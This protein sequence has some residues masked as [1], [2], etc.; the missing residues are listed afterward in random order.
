M[1]TQTTIQIK[2]KAPVLLQEIKKAKSVLLHCHPNPDPDSVGSALAMKFVLEQLGIK[3]TVIKGDSDIPE[4]FEHF[5]GCKEI[6]KKDYFEID[7]SQYDLFIIVDSASKNMIS[8]KKQVEFPQ[9][10]KTIVIDHHKSNE[11]YGSINLVEYT[12]PATAQ[13]LADLFLEWEIKLDQNISSNLFL[14]IY[15]DS[16]FKY[17]GVSTHTF[18]IATKLS[19]NI[20]SIWDLIE[21]METSFSPHEITFKKIALN[22]ISTSLNN[23][24]VISTV[25]LEEI[26]KE[27]IDTEEI[28][29]SFISTEL[30]SVKGWFIS[31]SL[32]ETK[33]NYVEISL[34][35]QNGEKYD[36]SKL[37]TA[38]GGGGHKAAAGTTLRMSIKEAKEQLLKKAEELYNL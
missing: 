25:S 24:L 9:H 2:D 26:K 3:A 14:G 1:N 16:L 18:E 33:E 8:K 19:E 13:I 31:A 20:K 6:V 5:L 38:L 23:H 34:R 28:R 21:P 32:I 15:S 27:K 10:L 12:Y 22:N 30:R 4:A 35:S 17:P 29:G 37:A 36:V 11:N 7:L